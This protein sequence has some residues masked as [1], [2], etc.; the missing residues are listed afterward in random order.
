M[1]G[2]NIVIPM[3]YI[4]FQWCREE[5]VRSVA[6]IMLAG[7]HERSMDEAI[8][9]LDEMLKL[10][11]EYAVFAVFSPY[12]GTGD[13]FEDGA[14]KSLPSRLLGST[15]ARSIVRCRS[16]CMLGRTSK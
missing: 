14:K 8:K 7:P 6:Y 4:A 2:V 3:M 16:T 1:L 12:P 5:G 9:N 10:D 15:N 13:S 11:A